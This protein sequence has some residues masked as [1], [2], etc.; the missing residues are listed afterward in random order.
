MSRLITITSGKGGVGKTNISVNLALRLATLGYKT[1]L[2]D[3]DMGLAN[4]NILLGINPELTLEDILYDGKDINDILIKGYH[5]ID[6]IPG[7][8]GVQK[9]ADLGPDEI[10]K[11]TNSLSQIPSYDYVIFDTSA[12][13]SKEVISFCMTSSE[14][15][16]IITPEPTSL[17]DAYSLLKVLT[18]NDFNDS[19]MVA[20]NQ[21]KDLDVANRA[22]TKF[23]AAVQKHLGLD[24]L[25][26][27][28]IISD[29]NVVN[30]VKDQK[31][32]II[33]YPNCNASKCIKNIARHLINKEKTEL[34]DIPLDT[35][36]QR[37]L[38]WL[39]SPLQ[40]SRDPKKTA[41]QE[42]ADEVTEVKK[43][44]DIRQQE[45]KESES[46]EKA[47]IIPVETNATLPKQEET[48]S[49]SSSDIGSALTNISEGIVLISKELK[50]IRIIME[51]GEADKDSRKSEPEETNS[52]PQEKTVVTNLR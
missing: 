35:F 50:A 43:D 15:M 32:F 22:F 11:I 49:R 44:A 21:C 29:P 5:G 18:L 9:M 28:T 14:I 33:Q 19:V 23:K 47:D 2:F 42:S 26:A 46:K 38:R 51:V 10:Q 8:S 13:I 36:W 30:S 3:A 41:E 1:C 25:P 39:N 40:L 37:C 6:I 17:T 27:G 12:G 52:Y 20:V 4:I 7:S 16:L 31:P 24:I 45:Q 34:T 48:R